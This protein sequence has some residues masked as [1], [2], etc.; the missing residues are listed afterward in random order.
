MSHKQ[1]SDQELDALVVRS[2]ARLPSFAPSRDFA[3]RVMAQVQLQ[4]RP[5]AL[6]RRAVGWALEPRRA[7][8][9]AGSY[10]AAAI[11]ALAVTVPWLLAHRPEIGFGLDWLVGRSQALVHQ[12]STALV[13]WVLASGIAELLQALPVSTPA[14]LT[15]G[16]LIAAAYA[17]CAILLRNLLRAPRGL[18]ALPAQA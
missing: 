7:L 8:V 6:Y 5:I 16:S 4:P 2:L 11:L 12:A 10:A 9:L 1:L 14:A 15:F 18:D 13:G 17:G 3:A